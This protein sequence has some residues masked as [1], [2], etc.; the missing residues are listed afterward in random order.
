[1]TLQNIDLQELL[2][3]S[4]WDFLRM[5]VVLISLYVCI[6]CINLL[7]KVFA[8]LLPL[9][10]QCEMVFDSAQGSTTDIAVLNC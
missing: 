6:L 8:M 2:L 1:M 4:D 5:Q 3:F 7:S 9:L 10:L